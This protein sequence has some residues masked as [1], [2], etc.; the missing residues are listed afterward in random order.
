MPTCDVREGKIIFFQLILPQNVCS[1]HM[2]GQ[3]HEIIENVY[4]MVTQEIF[5]D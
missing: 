1:V 3:S 4:R 5:H 2:L